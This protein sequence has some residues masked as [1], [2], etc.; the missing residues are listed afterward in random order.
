[1]VAGGCVVD[2]TIVAR[3]LDFGHNDSPLAAL[4][5]REHQTLGLM[6]E[7]QSNAAIAHH[8]GIGER[9]VESVCGQLFR[10]LSLEPDPDVNR[11]VLAVLA[12]LRAR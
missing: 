9:T 3:L 11:R 12:L 10:K 6:A 2:P 5:P 4:S 1:V 7:G 8:L